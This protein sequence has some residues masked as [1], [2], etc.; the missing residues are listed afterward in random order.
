MRKLLTDIPKKLNSNCPEM[1][2]PMIT[3]KATIEAFLAMLVR[4]SLVR[5]AVIVI[6]TGIVPNGFINVKKEVK[7]KRAKEMV[8]DIVINYKIDLGTTFRV[9]VL[10]RFILPAFESGFEVNV[11]SQEFSGL[12]SSF[13]P[14]RTPLAIF[15]E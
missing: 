4:F 2:K 3:K 9:K 13:I 8:S 1:A 7:H 10:S 11:V 12:N 6:K 14:L 5:S 15:L